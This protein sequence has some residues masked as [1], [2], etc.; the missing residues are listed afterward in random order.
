V[1]APIQPGDRVLVLQAEDGSRAGAMSSRPDTARSMMYND[2]T[3]HM[4]G[5][6]VIERHAFWPLLFSAPSKQP[7]KVLP[8][9]SALSVFEG[10]PPWIGSLPDPRPVDIERAPYLRHWQ[11]FDWVLVLWPGWTAD[12]YDLLPTRLEPVGSGHVAALYRI[13]K[14]APQ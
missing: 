10:V 2:A 6:V 14:T 12:G 1:I 7:V 8:P 11:D 5:L 4:A 9:Y 3:M 13:R